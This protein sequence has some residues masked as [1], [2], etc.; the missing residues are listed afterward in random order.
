[1]VGKGFS[2]KGG[3]EMRFWLLIAVVL[4]LATSAFGLEKRVYQLSEDY[5][6]EVLQPP[7]C[8][9]QYY[10]FIPCIFDS[11]PPVSYFWGFS[12]WQPGEV[13]AGSYRIGDQAMDNCP[14]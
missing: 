12:G 11:V 6:S 8:Q 1:M 10:Y 5:R 13:I 4:V 2:R 14:L 3:D 9:L 7:W